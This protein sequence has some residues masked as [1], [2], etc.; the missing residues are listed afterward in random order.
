MADKGKAPMET[1][2]DVGFQGK[3]TFEVG[4]TSSP[5]STVPPSSPA[6]VPFRRHPRMRVIPPEV[7]DNLRRRGFPLR[8]GPIMEAVR[9]FPPGYGPHQPGIA[10]TFVPE[11]E[12]DPEEEEEEEEEDSDE[13]DPEE[14]FSEDEEMEPVFPDAPSDGD[15]GVVTE[16]DYE[17]ESD[18]DPEELVIE[19]EEM[20]EDRDM[21]EVL[22]TP[23]SFRRWLAH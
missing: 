14:E 6:M 13:E 12:E 5:P 15:M 23:R 22:I 10:S 3:S 7:L 21:G 4:S 9:D 20:L 16:D 8:D 17:P 19:H 2:E 18:E 11:P 1:S